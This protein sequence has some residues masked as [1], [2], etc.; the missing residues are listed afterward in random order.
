MAYVNRKVMM[1]TQHFSYVICF[2]PIFNANSGIYQV[3][4]NV[5]LNT[6]SRPS[7]QGF[8]DPTRSGILIYFHE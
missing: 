4:S 5:G 3:L 2:I 8:D 6:E 1:V 7:I